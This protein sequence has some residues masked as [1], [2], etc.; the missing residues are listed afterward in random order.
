MKY[1]VSC[2]LLARLTVGCDQQKPDQPLE[3][4]D[5]TL[6]PPPTPEDGFQYS[7]EP[8]DIGPGEEIQNCYFF[9]VPYDEDIC[10]GRVVVA[11][12]RGTH[13]MNIFRPEQGTILDLDGEP[14]DAVLGSTDRMNPCW[15]SGNWA[16]WPLVMNSQQST[17]DEPTYDWTLPEGVAMKFHAREK[18]M[19]QSHYVNATTQVGDRGVVLVNFERVPCEGTDEL[20]T[21]FATNQSINV[22]PGD[23]DREF[24]SSCGNAFEQPV[25]IVAANSHF[26]S[27]GRH[28]DIELYDP[29]A[30]EY[31]EP[32]YENVNWDEPLMAK[33]L[34]VEVPA[35]QRIG[36]HCSYDYA[37]PREPATCANLADG[38]CYAFGP[39]VE[40]SEHC[41]IFVYYYPKLA[42][43][44]CN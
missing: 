44:S 13:H 18:L 5:V 6:D 1:V 39:V 3:T 17:P 28:F 42:D 15:R 9:E 30:D 41:N 33:D 25:T 21:M 4:E 8:F 35:G 10:V 16:D 23:T 7:I 20:G 36:W 12:N 40:T 22:C 2:A 27:R 24:D 11:Q 34:H 37:P 31:G 38:C 32:F 43:Y 29:V 19:L 26:H 14:G